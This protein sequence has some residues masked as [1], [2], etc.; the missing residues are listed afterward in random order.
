MDRIRRGGHS[1]TMNNTK[2]IH[3]YL[4]ETGEQLVRM[5]TDHPDHA[6][7]LAALGNLHRALAA[8][9]AGDGVQAE[10]STER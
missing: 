6:D 5:A 2:P 10:K 7:M 8:E 1:G 3:D 9:N 4:N